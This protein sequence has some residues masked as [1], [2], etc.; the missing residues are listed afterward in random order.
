MELL[1]A[2]NMIR[3]IQKIGLQLYSTPQGSRW[4]KFWITINSH[5]MTHT[6]LNTKRFGVPRC[7][8][9]FAFE[10]F[11]GI[12]FYDTKQLFLISSYVSFKLGILKR[13]NQRHKNGKS[14]GAAMVRQ[15]WR[16]TLI[17]TVLAVNSSSLEAKEKNLPEKGVFQT[18]D[19]DYF[20]FTNKPA[21]RVFHNISSVRYVKFNEELLFHTFNLNEVLTTAEQVHLY[22]IKYMWSYVQIDMDFFL[23]NQ[24]QIE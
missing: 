4:D 8:A 20:L 24:T 22:E 17:D 16:N 1:D 19:G 13:Y 6:A 9:V 5:Y 14:E 11:L 18:F 21:Q 2:Q 15:Y 10:S 3:E 7:T 12:T 23:Y